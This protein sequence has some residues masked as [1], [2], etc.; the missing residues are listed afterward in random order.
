ENKRNKENLTPSGY[1]SSIAEIQKSERQ[2]RRAATPRTEIL[3]RDDGVREHCRCACHLDNFGGIQSIQPRDVAVNSIRTTSA[4]DTSRPGTGYVNVSVLESR[5]QSAPPALQKAYLRTLL[6]RQQLRAQLCAA[7]EYMGRHSK[8]FGQD[9]IRERVLRVKQAK[10]C[11]KC[12]DNCERYRAYRTV[13]P[14]TVRGES[15]FISDSE[16]EKGQTQYPIFVVNMRT[17]FQA[18]PKHNHI[19]RGNAPHFCNFVRNKKIHQREP[20]APPTGHQHARH[21]AQS[22]GWKYQLPSNAN[23]GGSGRE[24][25]PSSP[26]DQNE[27]QTSKDEDSVQIPWIAIKEKAPKCVEHKPTPTKTAWAQNGISNS[28]GY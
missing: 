2:I 27:G 15:L 22:P 17:N 4:R 13:R 28:E 12:N 11:G 10:G 23:A 1:E 25:R 9:V 8:C 7:P 19:I 3:L 21:G 24:G 16:R 26:V 20:P 18:L 6:M 5:P 14:S